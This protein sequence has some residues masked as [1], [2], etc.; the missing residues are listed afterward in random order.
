MKRILIITCSIDVT[1][2]YIIRHYRTSCLFFRFN[3]D[4]LNDYVVDIDNTGWRITRNNESIN[5]NSVHS[6]YY[7]K[8]RYPDLSEYGVEY[9][10]MIKRDILSLINGIVDEFKG[11]VLTKPSILRKVENKIYQLLYAIKK[12]IEIP[13][14][15][16]GNSN[17]AC[18]DFFKRSSI[19]KPLTTGKI[20]CA[21]YAEMYP[22]SLFNSFDE[23]FDDIALTPVYL[24]DYIDK[25]YEVRITVVG[26]DIFTVRIDTNN[27][28]DWRS[29]YKNVHYQI[30]DIPLEIKQQCFNMLTDFDLSFGIFDYVVTPK[31]RWVFLEINPNGQ[32]LWLEEELNLNI[33]EKII[34]HLVD[35]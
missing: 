27:K 17:T 26:H 5:N 11:K 30:I 35:G 20:L 16:I 32:W 7:R 18:S 4:Q 12:G 6:I 13:V 22:T 1:V 34:S 29:D 24:Q 3:V 28:I 15:Y 10:A 2:D 8:P 19:I 21:N 23:D 25:Q 9:H 33:S 14:S 31:N